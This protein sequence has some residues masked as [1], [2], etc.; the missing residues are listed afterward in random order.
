MVSPNS[1][2]RSSCYECGRE[3]AKAKKVYAGNRYCGTC[4]P[5]LFKR[6]MC[7]S[8]GNHAR[9]PIFDLTADCAVCER[10]APCVRCCKVEFETALLTQFGPVCKSCVPYFRDME[11]CEKC[12]KVSQRLSRSK[13]TGL[14]CCPACRG[15]AKATCPS[16]R[17][18]RALILGPDGVPRCEPC[19]V[20]PAQPCD[21][22]GALTPAGRGS[23]CE[24]CYWLRIFQR[25]LA[26][27]SK[28]FS[29]DQIT[30]AFTQFGQWLLDRS[31]AH[32]AALSINAHYQFFHELDVTW[33]SVPSYRELLEHF[34]TA[35]LRKAE[36][37]MRWL[38]ETG[39]VTVSAQLKDQHTE[40][41]RLEA[42]LAE[43]ADGWSAQLLSE[44]VTA[45]KARM[46]RG[47]TDL[48]S[49]RLAARAAANLLKSAWLKVGA[50]PTQKNLESFWRESP[51]Q[52]AAV[53]G[54]IG[55]LNKYHDLQ[56]QAK[57]DERLLHQA[58]RQKAE[59]ELVAL[60]SETADAEFESRWIVKGL[61]YFHGMMRV[62]RKTLVYQHQDYRGVAGYN[63][64][65]GG[66]VLWVP[67]AGSYQ[68]GDHSV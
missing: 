9:L 53:T 42:I 35:G 63:I 61:A 41:R 10:A 68:R 37:P 32:K 57:P 48:R 50:L 46:E 60:L 66:K 8:C 31:G 19:T 55:Y 67:S 52:V 54:F 18:H 5:R 1:P 33:R 16:C 39:A 58:K 51:G 47:G 43:P 34:D 13:A 56:L 22:C 7:P 21:S 28:G 40:Q 11:P 30:I 38:T 29:A 49:I 62:S 27:N 3:M 24:A 4:Y 59:R 44:Y 15:P 25:R 36:N 45:L 65:H 20:K 17:R 6:R 23:E 12:G 2:T 64:T 14:R 26:I